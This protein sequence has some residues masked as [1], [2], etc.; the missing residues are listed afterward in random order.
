ME[1][2]DSDSDNSEESDQG[3]EPFDVE[4][5]LESDFM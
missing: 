3:Y 1:A 4:E 2:S 5:E